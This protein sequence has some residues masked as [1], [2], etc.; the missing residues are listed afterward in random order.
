MWECM[1]CHSKS[2]KSIFLC[3][4]L[5]LHF[6][7]DLQCANHTLSSWKF[8]CHKEQRHY[9]HRLGCVCVCGGGVP[10]STSLQ[11]EGKEYT[12][13]NPSTSHTLLNVLQDWTWH[14]V[15]LCVCVCL[16]SPSVTRTCARLCSTADGNTTHSVCDRDA[17]C[18]CQSHRHCCAVGIPHIAANS[19]HP[20]IQWQTSNHLIL[21]LA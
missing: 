17:A 21:N 16:N 2:G 20:N 6:C 5:L 8:A 7:S 1:R 13:K 10:G 3:L 9:W 18:S 12:W 4:Q 11:H 15:S 14:A 19:I